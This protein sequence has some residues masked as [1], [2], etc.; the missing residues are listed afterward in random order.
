MWKSRLIGGWLIEGSW[1][2]T[3]EFDDLNEDRQCGGGWGK[4]QEQIMKD[5]DLLG[6]AMPVC[7]L[8]IT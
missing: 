2:L 7:A 6:T 1:E 4:N 5:R 3:V 8:I